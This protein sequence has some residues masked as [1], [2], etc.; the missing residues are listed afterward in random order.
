MAPEPQTNEPIYLKMFPYAPYLQLGNSDNDKDKPKR[1]TLPK[2]MQLEEVNE[3]IALEL[4]ALPRLLGEHPDTGKEI[5]ASIGP[6]GPYV[7]HDK[8][9]ASLKK[10]D[11]VL[12]IDLSRAL[13]LIS[14]KE[15]KNKPLRVLGHDPKTGMEIAIL[16]GRYG[17]YIKFKK[18]N[19]SLP[20]QLKVESITLD[21]ALE[22]IAS[23]D[24]SSSKTSK[25]KSKTPAK[26][27]DLSELV[28][29]LDKLESQ[30][31]AVISR[32]EGLAGQAK[33]DILALTDSLGLSEEEISALHKKALFKL[34]MAYG[35]AKREGTA[36]KPAKKP[37]EK[38]AEKSAE[39]SAKKSASKSN[40]KKA[41]KAA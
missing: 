32:L 34:R 18:L 29:F 38:P 1:V 10:D 12:S 31:R 33:E 37:V 30:E 36:E 2:G 17:P 6:F 28:P 25:S 11:D 40:S 4:I 3:D 14:D 13:E 7:K 23:K 21:E 35:R 5:T 19:I 24:S 20:R 39:K 15:E 8:L 26:S 27:S 22:L 9:Y 16:K 41:S